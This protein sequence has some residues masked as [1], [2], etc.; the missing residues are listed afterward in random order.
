MGPGQASR[1]RPGPSR[2]G[3][4]YPAA[5]DRADQR[6]DP[7]NR[8]RSG[9]PSPSRDI[10]RLS[11]SF[12]SA[13]PSPWLWARPLVL[14]PPSSYRPRTNKNGPSVN[15]S[16]GFD[17]GS[18][19]CM[20]DLDLWRQVSQPLTWWKSTLAPPFCQEVRA[21][22]GGGDEGSSPDQA[23]SGPSL[24]ICTTSPERTCLKAVA[25]PRQRPTTVTGLAGR[26]SWAMLA[27]VGPKK[28]QKAV[29]G[30]Q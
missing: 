21:A 6:P 28:M 16:A 3:W 18:T 14:S 23:R 30:S 19:W 12:D 29:P 10:A 15:G 27:G 20:S 8:S 25:S 11:S 4:E 1:S 13:P 5:R 22:R 24:S 17:I 7:R 26:I 9:R 2:R